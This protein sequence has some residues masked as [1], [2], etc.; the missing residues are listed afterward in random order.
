LHV[1]R[2]TVVVAMASSIAMVGPGVFFPAEWTHGTSAEAAVRTRHQLLKVARRTPAYV[3]PVEEAERVYGYELAVTYAMVQEALQNIISYVEAVQ[4]E[5]AAEA[6]RQAEATRLAS[7][8]QSTPQVAAGGNGG[9]AGCASGGGQLNGA[10]MAI[11]QR[12]SGGDYCA[13]N[14]S[15]ACGAYQIM[16]GTWNGYGGYASACDAPPAVQDEKARS[17]AACNWD[18]PNY[19]SGG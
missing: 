18:P 3:D 11:I 9:G 6:A 8:Q 16:P 17:M 14:P 7:Q 15:G 10:P 13:R 2:R 12:E 5:Q 4:A 1:L 19:C